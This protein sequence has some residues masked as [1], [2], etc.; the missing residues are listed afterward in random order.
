MLLLVLDQL[1]DAV[2]DYPLQWDFARDHIR[3]LYMSCYRL[4]LAVFNLILPKC[5]HQTKPVV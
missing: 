4:L 2:F 1:P 3:G 5:Q